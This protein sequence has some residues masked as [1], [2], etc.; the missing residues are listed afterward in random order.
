MHRATLSCSYNFAEGLDLTTG[1]VRVV[2][3]NITD[4]GVRC[5]DNDRDV[6]L[7]CYMGRYLRPSSE[8]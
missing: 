5:P 8:Y 6:D 7:R 3:D 2:Q 1:E 4:V